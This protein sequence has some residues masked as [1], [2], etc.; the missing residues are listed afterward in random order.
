MELVAAA[1][2]LSLAFDCF[3]VAWGVGALR[4]EAGSLI[5]MKLAT[6]FG[7]FQSG[8][9]LAGWGAGSKL[10][11]IAAEYDHWIAFTLLMGVAA[12][13]IYDAFRNG[14]SMSNAKLTPMLLLALSI[15]TSVDALAAG[16]SLS[17]LRSWI[18]ASAIIAGLSSFILTMTGYHLGVRSRCA[19]GDRATAVGGGILIIVG[20]K[21]LVD[22][23]FA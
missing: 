8:M 9:L 6:Y 18:V 12:H 14:C 3:S 13:M 10:A 7:A 4:G 23:L 5:D 17:F 22:H 16:F 11:G 15:A 21:I 19:V 20:L 1:V 2:A